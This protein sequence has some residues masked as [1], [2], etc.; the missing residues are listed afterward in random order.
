MARY[1]YICTVLLLCL[2]AAACRKAEPAVHRVTMDDNGGSL[3]MAVG[4]ELQV[5]LPEMQF[6]GYDWIAKYYDPGA[7]EIVHEG[8]ASQR[9][10]A[11]ATGGA[12]P[13]VM[14]FKAKRTAEFTLLLVHEQPN[15]SGKPKETFE[16]DITI[17]KEVPKQKLD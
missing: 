7:F 3:T 11:V 8:T 16:L 9:G 15:K 4:D 12:V 6:E 17:L 13:E 1:V 5:T 2:F 10:I 14:L